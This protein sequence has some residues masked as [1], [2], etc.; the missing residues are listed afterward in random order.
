M[1][2]PI[3]YIY[4]YLSTAT[5]SFLLFFFGPHQLDWVQN[6]EKKHKKSLHSHLFYDRVNKFSL[7][8]SLG[9]VLY[10]DI[11]PPSEPSS[12]LRAVRISSFFFPND[13][14]TGEKRREE[15]ERSERSRE[16]FLLFFK[17]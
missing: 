4:I 7:S 5:S 9:V 10:T 2:E 17:P 11:F 15:P 12:A 14:K 13:Y 8:L 16:I 3:A 6:A 1:D